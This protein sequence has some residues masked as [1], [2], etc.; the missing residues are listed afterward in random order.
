MLEAHGRTDRPVS[1]AMHHLLQGPALLGDERQTR[2]TEI[3]EVE[4][5]QTG[6]RACTR[7][8]RSDVMCLK[9]SSTVVH[10]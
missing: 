7:S 2:V 4:L 9:G 5:R 6:V 8:G 1:T 3:V 10:E